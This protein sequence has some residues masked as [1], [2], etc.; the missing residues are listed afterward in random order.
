MSALE[1]VTVG[2]L[3]ELRWPLQPLLDACGLTAEALACRVGAS[4]TSVRAAARDGLNDL[5]AD[6]WAIRLGTHPLI[7]WGWAWIDDGDRAEGRPA[8]I[9]LAAALRD[10]IEDGTLAFGVAVPTV[11]V[12]AETWGVGT[13]TAAE[14]IAE[15]RRQGLVLGGGRGHPNV[16]SSRTGGTPARCS[17]CASAIAAGEE[18]Y[19]HRPHCA[20]AERGWCDCGDATHPECCPTC[21]RGAS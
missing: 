6:A 5:Q 1:A 13:K 11:V 15:L 21:A 19:P 20:L 12:L 3:P 4:G 10:Q 14:A 18:H 9:R 2:A 17:L 8:S 7:V 16:V